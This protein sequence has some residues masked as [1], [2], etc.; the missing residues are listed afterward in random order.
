MTDREKLEKVIDESRDTMR[1]EIARLASR[2]FLKECTA[3]G[4]NW[5][6]MLWTGFKRVHELGWI[7][8]EELEMFDKKSE[9]V[10]LKYD[11]GIAMYT[12]LCEMSIDITVRQILRE[13]EDEA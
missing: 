3:C 12:Y 4:G 8:D 13:M 1:E 11:G 10:N 6:A 5:V 9:E 2:K 7:T